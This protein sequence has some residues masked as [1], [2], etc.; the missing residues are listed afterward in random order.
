M[1]R[2]GCIE[3]RFAIPNA[4]DARKLFEAA[5][6]AEEMADDMPW[7]SEAREIAELIREGVKGVRCEGVK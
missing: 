1:A 6:I 4:D 5:M 3:I 2:M 7:N